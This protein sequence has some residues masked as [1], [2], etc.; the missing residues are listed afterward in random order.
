MLAPKKNSIGYTCACPDDK[1][2]SPEG[3]FCY[4]TTISPTLIV[5]SSSSILE[6]EQEHLGRQKIKE[7][8]LKNQIFRISAVAYDSLSGIS[9]HFD[10]NVFI[11]ILTVHLLYFISR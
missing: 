3:H 1:Q 5:G 8:P 11:I 6:I 7:I 9:K 2:L 10:C 4:E